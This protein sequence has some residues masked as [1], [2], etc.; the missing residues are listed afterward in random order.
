MTPTP[1]HAHAAADLAAYQTANA[2]LLQRLQLIADQT[3][4]VEPGNA[5]VIIRAVHRIA[6]GDGLGERPICEPGPICKR[7]HPI[8]EAMEIMGVSRS[9]V[10]EYERQ[11]LKRSAAGK[12]RYNH[13]EID[14]FMVGGVNGHSGNCIGA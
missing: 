11:G 6:T 1:D 13:I 8:E 3:A 2:A 12:P 5:M 7:W 4:H 9:T 14:R 10:Y